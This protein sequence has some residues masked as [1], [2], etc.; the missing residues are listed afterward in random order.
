M[1][2]AHVPAGYLL[3]RAMI[4]RESFASKGTIRLLLGFG[5][6]GSILPDLDMFYFYL[7]DNRQHSH[8][9]YWTHIPVFWGVVYMCFLTF[10]VLLRNKTFVLLTSILFL[11]VFIHLALDT[12]VGDI[13][14]LY[15]LSHEYVSFFEVTARYDWWVLN[16]VLHWSFLIELVFV[17]ASLRLYQQTRRESTL[18]DDSG[19]CQG[20]L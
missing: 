10:G 3:S 7:I 4:S 15:P 5:L 18:G 6:L 17:L 14:W 2:I 20:G 19:D 8:H 11:N 16:F 9:S 1:F 12:V 13:R